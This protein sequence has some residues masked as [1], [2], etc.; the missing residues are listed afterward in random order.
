MANGRDEAVGRTKEIIINER[1]KKWYLNAKRDIK[2]AACVT[3]GFVLEF[4][5]IN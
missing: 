2:L 1:K 5:F 3:N 4:C